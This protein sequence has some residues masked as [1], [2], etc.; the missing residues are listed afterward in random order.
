MDIRLRR[1]MRTCALEGER[2]TSLQARLQ[3]RT[4]R[5]IP[6]RPSSS[7]PSN[8]VCANVLTRSDFSHAPC[9]LIA[10]SYISH[11]AQQTIAS[12][13]INEPMR[14][15]LKRTLLLVLPLELLARAR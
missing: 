10:S 11:P 14:V 7:G 12:N 1:R 5:A 13:A 8:F 2:R 4:P 6:G 3:C 15:V 9:Y